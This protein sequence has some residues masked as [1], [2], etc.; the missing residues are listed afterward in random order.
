MEILDH[1][2]SSKGVHAEV[3]RVNICGEYYALKVVSGETVRIIVLDRRPRILTP[4]LQFRFYRAKQ[5]T[6]SSSTLSAENKQPWKAK[7]GVFPKISNR[8]DN[9]DEIEESYKKITVIKTP[10]K[11]RHLIEDSSRKKVQSKEK[12]A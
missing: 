10:I 7:I 11:R 12:A 5:L 4:F 1:I 2:T 3:F 9:A 8:R 6:A